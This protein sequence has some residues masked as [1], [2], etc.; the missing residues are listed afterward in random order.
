[1]ANLLVDKGVPRIAGDCRDGHGRGGPGVAI[2]GSGGKQPKAEANHR[3]RLDDD[4]TFHVR[5]SAFAAIVSSTARRP[6]QPSTLNRC[7]TWMRAQI[8]GRSSAMPV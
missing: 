4:P 3:E 5:I 2:G 8:A 6:I 7:G 1:V